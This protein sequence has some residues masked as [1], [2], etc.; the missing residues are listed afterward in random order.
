MPCGNP[1]NRS[2]DALR[3]VREIGEL[4]FDCGK[5][6]LNHWLLYHARQVQT[7]GSARTFVVAEAEDRVAGN[8]SPTLG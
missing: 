6:T 4:H 8:F 7:S 2:C 3:P 1:Y 5:P